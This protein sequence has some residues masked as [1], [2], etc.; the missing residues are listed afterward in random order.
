VGLTNGGASVQF[1]STVAD[2]GKNGKNDSF[3]LTWTGF[4]A[5]GA[6]KA[7]EI[8]VPCVTTWWGDREWRD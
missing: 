1:T 8:E 7:G 4:S 3:S 2:G 5:G 6:L